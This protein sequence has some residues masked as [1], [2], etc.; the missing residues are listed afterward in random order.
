MND[1]CG[2]NFYEQRILNGIVCRYLGA[3]TV[4]IIIYIKH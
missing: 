1:L 2:K 4:R 3:L